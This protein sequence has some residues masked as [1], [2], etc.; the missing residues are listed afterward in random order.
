VPAVPAIYFGT[1]TH[2]RVRPVRHHLAY[3]VASVFV[4]LDDLARGNLPNLLRYNK[5]GLFSVRDRDHGDQPGESISAFARRLVR[6]A[7][8]LG[9]ERI[10]MLCYPRVLGYGFNPLTTYFALDKEGRTRLMIFEVHNTFGGRHSYVTREF[11]GDAPMRHDVEK[12][13]RVSPFNRIEGSYVLRA[14]EPDEQVMVSVALST[15]EGPLLNAVFRGKRKPLSNTQ[16]LR[17]FFGL[18]WLSVK[19]IAAIHWEALKL[20]RK[21]LKLQS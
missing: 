6:E 16:L 8:V 1:V 21:G 7:G 13:L 15:A 19:V 3:D 4:D 12:Q 20:W 14:T 10:M 17:V 18:P 11:T 2:Q 9:I 5:P